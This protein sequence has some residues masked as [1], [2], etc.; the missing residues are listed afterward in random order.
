MSVKAYVPFT[1]ERRKRK[2]QKSLR[3]VAS[4]SDAL[5]QMEWS[6]GNVTLHHAYWNQDINGWELDNGKR[7]FPR[8]KGGDPKRLFG[9]PVIQCHSEETGPVSTEAAL[10]AGSLEQGEVMPVDQEG[11]PLEQPRHSPEVD[12]SPGQPS[13]QPETETDPLDGQTLSETDGA[14]TLND[15]FGESGD[16]DDDDMAAD[17]GRAVADFAP[18]FPSPGLTWDGVEY[19][20]ADAVLYDPFPVREDDARQAAEWAE[21][22]GRD[23]G[24]KLKYAAYGALGLLGVITFLIL[25]IWLLGQ[26]GGGDT[27]ISIM[28]GAE[29]FVEVLAL[30]VVASTKHITET[31]QNWRF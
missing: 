2:L 29:R 4:G 31:L 25:V 12:G 19:S 17:G 10:I 20:L 21:L 3:K 22:S 1:A 11:R 26:I 7:I 23:P 15:L 5:A 8:G 27:G 9:V 16:G 14:S 6:D 28:L 18:D 24:E 30:G 13:Q